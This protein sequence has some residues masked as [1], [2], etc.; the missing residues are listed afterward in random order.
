MSGRIELVL[1]P[2]FSG[3]STELMRRA[4][5]A[6]FAK[7][8]VIVIKYAGD[9]R[10]TDAVVLQTHDAATLAATFSA[11][12]LMPLLS[13]HADTFAAAHM[14]AIDE[15]Q[16]LPDLA[17]FAEKLANA[18]CVVVI[19]AL[20]SD[21]MRRAFKPITDVL[22]LAER[23]DKLTAVCLTCGGEAAFNRRTVVSTAVEL[24]GG[25]ESYAAACRGCHRVE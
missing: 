21:F 8:R 19:A 18:G 6:H 22:P 9:T 12:T 1:G 17:E 13:E 20:D 4:R 23:I 2:M 11:S 25:A 24:I 14:V 10:Y 15:G 16:F 3:K 7:R 5:R